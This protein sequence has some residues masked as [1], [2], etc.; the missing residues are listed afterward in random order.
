[1]KIQF[2]P[3]FLVKKFYI[4][5]ELLLLELLSLINQQLIYRES[6]LKFFVHSNLFTSLFVIYNKNSFFNIEKI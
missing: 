4:Y 1:M 5:M 3:L 2:F 6:F